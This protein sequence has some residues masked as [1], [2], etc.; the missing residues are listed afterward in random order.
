LLPGRFKSHVEIAG[1]NLTEGRAPALSLTLISC[2]IETLEIEKQSVQ[3][4]VPPQ[5]RIGLR[6][7]SVESLD[8]L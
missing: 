2:Q 6:S 1:S 8:R 4:A 3:L 7:S 5:R